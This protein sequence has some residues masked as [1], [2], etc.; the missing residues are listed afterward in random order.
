MS[1]YEKNPNLTKDGV[2]SPVADY[3]G[4]FYPP[5]VEDFRFNPDPCVNSVKDMKTLQ[6]FLVYDVNYA[7]NQDIMTY[8]KVEDGKIVS[9]S[10]Y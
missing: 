5:A 4:A 8:F 1:R 2:L 9:D 7:L 10:I 3:D 6:Q